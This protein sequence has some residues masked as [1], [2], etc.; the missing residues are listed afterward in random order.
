MELKVL[1]TP[2]TT[3][4]LNLLRRH[5]D[6]PIHVRDIA[7]LGVTYLGSGKE[8]SNRIEVHLNTT[9]SES[10]QEAVFIHELLHILMR[11]QGFPGI[12]IRADI[13]SKLASNLIPHLEKSRDFFS[14]TIDHLK[15]YETMQNEFNLDLNSYFKDQVEGKIRRFGK[16]SYQEHP[17]DAEYFF[18]VQ[19]D[20]LDGLNYYLFPEPFKQEILNIFKLKTPEGFAACSTLFG[21]VSK[22]GF[23]KP[24]QIFKCAGVIKDQIV[25]Y[26]KKKSVGVLNQL[27]LELHVVRD[28]RE[29]PLEY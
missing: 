1:Q 7:E 5:I 9:V 4:L 23:F 20:I 16:F 22:I 27:Y 11:N 3:K 10:V 15:I 26:G 14:S 19:Q 18:H 28:A 2:N 12:A 8:Y 24:E 25:N 6:K 29:I 17:K 13:Q 21:K